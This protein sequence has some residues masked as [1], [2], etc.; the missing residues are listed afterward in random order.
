MKS[1]AGENGAL[2]IS[3][4]AHKHHKAR[5]TVRKRLENVPFTAG[6]KGALLYDAELAAAAIDAVDHDWS[7]LKIERLRKLKAER[8]LLEIELGKQNGSLIPAQKVYEIL[9]NCFIGI[10]MKILG[11]SLSEVEQDRLLNDLASLKDADL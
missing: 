10:K 4:L 3:Q 11:S 8:E 5:E 1:P 2:S 7:E 6:P 9:E